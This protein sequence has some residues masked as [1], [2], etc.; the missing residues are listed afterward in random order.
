MYEGGLNGI[1][2]GIEKPNH[3]GAMKPMTIG[4]LAVQ[5]GHSWKA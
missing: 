3:I 5:F 4:I 2:V 1:C